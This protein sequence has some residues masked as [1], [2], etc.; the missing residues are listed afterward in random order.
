MTSFKSWLSDMLEKLEVDSDMYTEYIVGMLEEEENTIEENA[1]T[2][3]EFL[4]AI[5]DISESDFAKT[6]I[7]KFKASQKTT[8]SSSNNSTTD[9]QEEEDVVSRTIREARE[10]ASQRVENLE[11]SK[12]E[13]KRLVEDLGLEEYLYVSEDIL[14]DKEDVGEEEK[15]TN[16]RR[17]QEERR[18]KRETQK[19]KSKAK[20]ERDKADLKRDKARKEKR[21]AEARKRAA[22]GERRKKR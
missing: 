18:K 2:A 21:L 4:A 12:R 16:R 15:N 17:V 10:F 9:D 7:E 13:R 22:K 6:L 11:T 20:K 14:A 8:E 3:T 5:A 1:R 19:K